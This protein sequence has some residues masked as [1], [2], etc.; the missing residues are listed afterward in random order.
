MSAA[1][2]DISLVS[3]PGSGRNERLP[4]NA[5]IYFLLVALTAAAVTIPFVGRLQ[6]KIGRAHV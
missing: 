1:P 6:S 5:R 4:R 2:T 3:E